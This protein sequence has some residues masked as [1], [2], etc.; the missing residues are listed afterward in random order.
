M[1][2]AGQIAVLLVVEDNRADARLVEEAFKEITAPI[3]FSQVEDG[4]EAMNILR[5][6][7]GHANAPRPNLIL[8]DLN[9]PRKDGREVLAELKAD[10]ELR[11]IPVV[12]MTSSQDPDDVSKCYDLGANC[13]VAK[14]L[15]YDEF[16]RR[17]KSLADFWLTVVKLPER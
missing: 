6:V 15:E 1:D 16:F 2:D 14:A 13:Y 3:H 7:G 9:L 5:R 10:P 8:L 12:I 4:E 17:M 11:R